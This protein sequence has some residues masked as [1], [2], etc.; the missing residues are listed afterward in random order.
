[1]SVVCDCKAVVYKK[2]AT[3][4]F[5]FTIIIRVKGITKLN[6]NSVKNGI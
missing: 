6:N 5:I 3:I 1:M 2:K 4:I